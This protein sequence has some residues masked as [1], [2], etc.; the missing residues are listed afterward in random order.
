M[1]QKLLFLINR[2]WT[3]PVLDR[4]MALLSSFDAWI[5][6]MV[7]LI[8][9]LFWRGGF[10]ARAFVLCAGLIVGIND[11]VISNALKHLVSRPRPHQS[12]DGVRQVDLGKA[13]PRFLALAKPLKI[14]LS[15]AA[16][17]LD[18]IAGRSFPSSHT[19]NTTSVALLTACFYRRRG[20]L[21]FIPA[22]GVAYSR[23]Y[24][25][26]HWPTDVLAS[27]FLGLGA[28]L[29]LLC[30]LE[31]LWQKWGGHLS[32]ALHEQHPSLLHS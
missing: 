29:L 3:G 13:T 2:Q 21:A 25:G 6:P 22:L 20:W 5:P 23:I 16:P 4:L 1:D 12:I 30:A 28:T 26:S 9:L 14:K 19:I 10:H 24:T 8:A 11:G 7:L 27:I 17:D 31:W 18:E 15:E 32:S